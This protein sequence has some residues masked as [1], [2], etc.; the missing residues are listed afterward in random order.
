MDPRSAA[1]GQME[2]SLG[3]HMVLAASGIG[4][5]LLMLMAE[6]L[7]WT[8]Q[9]LGERCGLHRTFIGSVERGERNASVLNLRAVAAAVG[10]RHPD[11]ALTASSGRGRPLRRGGPAPTGPAGGRGRRS[12]PTPGG[13]RRRPRP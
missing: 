5:P 4:M 3:F 7:G 13:R 8:Q 9:R 11:P 1:R 10:E 2:L 12:A 6:G